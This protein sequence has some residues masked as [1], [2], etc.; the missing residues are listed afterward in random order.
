M[1][2]VG[3]L[4]PDVTYQGYRMVRANDDAALMRAVAAQSVA[5]R[6]T[7]SGP[8]FN[9]YGGGIF[10]G[11]CNTTLGHA[12]V[13]VGYGTDARY[14]DEYWII[15]NS[16]GTGWGEAGYMLLSRDVGGDEGLCGIL[17][18]PS[19]PLWSAPAPRKH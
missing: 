8:F 13:V 12:V 6:I 17:K 9:N 15:K 14:G 16:W 19:Y 3:S 10:L 11:P 1:A 5:V 2:A 18:E 4:T 7:A